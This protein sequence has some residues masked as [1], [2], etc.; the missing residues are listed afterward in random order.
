M[1]HFLEFLTITIVLCQPRG[2][3][4]YIMGMA[5][6]IHIRI[7]VRIAAISGHTIEQLE[8]LKKRHFMSTT[9]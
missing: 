7:M 4:Y 3:S 8:K 9:T 5:L 6:R 1:L 2:H